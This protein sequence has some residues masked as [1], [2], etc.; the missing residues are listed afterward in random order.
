MVHWVLDLGFN[1][2]HYVRSWDIMPSTGISFAIFVCCLD[3][4]KASELA[5]V[6][7]VASQG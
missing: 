5:G 7:A 6:T 4:W 3:I 2:N 1:A